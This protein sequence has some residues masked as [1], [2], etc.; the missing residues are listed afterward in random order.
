MDTPIGALFMLQVILIAINAF[1]AAA[2]IAIV[3]LNE[4]K[5]RRQM[6][7]GDKKAGKLLSQG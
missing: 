5:L 6:E 3:S 7:E 4:N 2:E 1:F